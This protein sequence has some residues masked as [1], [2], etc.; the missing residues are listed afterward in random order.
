MKKI[1]K[2]TRNAILALFHVLP[3]HQTV[4]AKAV[5]KV[6]IYKIANVCMDVTFL[7]EPVK[8]EILSIVQP[9]TVV[10]NCQEIAAKLMSVLIQAV[11]SV[12]EA[13]IC[14][15][16]IVITLHLV[17]YAH[18]KTVLTVQYSQI[19]QY[20]ILAYYVW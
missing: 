8:P 14:L 4:A 9:A 12:I 18:N 19:K 17:T 10:I 2:K 6:S 16:K 20:H 7:V 1:K 5:W 11:N 15:K 3:V 13:N